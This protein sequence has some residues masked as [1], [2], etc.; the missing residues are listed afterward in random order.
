MT[1][2]R[3]IRRRMTLI[4]IWS[5]FFALTA[6]GII[7]AFNHTKYVSDGTEA[8]TVRLIHNAELMYN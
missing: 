2:A 1:E 8:E 5:L 4:L 6:T 3:K 7:T